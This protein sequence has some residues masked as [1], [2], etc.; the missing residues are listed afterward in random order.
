LVN[1]QKINIPSYQVKPDQVINL[2]KESMMGNKL[3][4]SSLEQN[5]KV[6]PY[7]NFDRQKLVITYLRYPITE[8]FNKGINTDLVME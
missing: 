8:E 5:I 6:P 7:I 4:K 1:D 3:V 2:R